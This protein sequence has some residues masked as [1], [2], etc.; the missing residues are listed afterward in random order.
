VRAAARASAP[1]AAA[2]NIGR[3]DVIVDDL[4]FE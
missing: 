3:I 2:S 4:R 1:A